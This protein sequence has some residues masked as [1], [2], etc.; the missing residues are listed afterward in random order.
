VFITL[1]P[2]IFLLLDRETSINELLEWL[3][4]HGV[5]YNSVEI[6]SVEYGYGLFAKEDLEPDQIPLQ[7][8]HT[9]ILSLDYGVECP[10]IK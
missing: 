6:K 9:A 5:D 3:E 10:D 7:L 2:F 4:T 1:Q 8:P